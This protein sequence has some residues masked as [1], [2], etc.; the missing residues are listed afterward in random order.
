MKTLYVTLLT[1]GLLLGLSQA[2]AQQAQQAQAQQ[3]QA[4]PVSEASIRELMEVTNAKRLVEGMTGQIETLI[5]RGVSEALKDKPVTP[6]ME[7]IIQRMIERV[8]QVTRE[9]MVWERLEPDFIALYRETFSQEEVDGML[10]FYKSPV[11]QSVNQKMPLLVQNSLV[12]TQRRMASIMGKMRLIQ[13]E[14]VAEI[15]QLERQPKPCPEADAKGKSK[16]KKSDCAK[17]R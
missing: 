9:E 1:L 15:Q 11:G 13:A 10:A 2:Q 7:A 6:E 5:K 12:Q 4:Q 14:T 16:G 8:A 3:T 17:P